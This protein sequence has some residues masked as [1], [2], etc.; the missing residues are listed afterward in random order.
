MISAFNV[1]DGQIL[2][3]MFVCFTIPSKPCSLY[4]LN[5]LIPSPRFQGGIQEYIKSRESYYEGCKYKPESER[6]QD[7]FD[8][9]KV[10]K[11]LKMNKQ[12]EVGESSAR[13]VGLHGLG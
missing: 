11:A 4:F 5:L 6:Q 8:E 12:V 1:R 7:L 9:D 3:S 10:E 13:E 2:R